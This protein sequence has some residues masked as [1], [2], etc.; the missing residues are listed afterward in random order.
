[1]S[2]SCH[3]HLRGLWSWWWSSDVKGVSPVQCMWC[4]AFSTLEVSCILSTK[5]ACACYWP[6]PHKLSSTR[7]VPLSQTIIMGIVRSRP[8]LHALFAALYAGLYA[9]PMNMF[10][11]LWQYVLVEIPNRYFSTYKCIVHNVC[12]CVQFYIRNHA[13]NFHF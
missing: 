2:C 12:M 3:L 11:P 4:R 8:S 7:K 9:H 1:M 5:H 6:W 13:Y 10:I